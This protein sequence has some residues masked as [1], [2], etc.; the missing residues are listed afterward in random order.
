MTVKCKSEDMAI[1]KQPIPQY[2]PIIKEA[3]R[4]VLIEHDGWALGI[5]ALLV[6]SGSALETILRAKN[7]VENSASPLFSRIF[8]TWEIL[9][10]WLAQL[11]HL[12]ATRL[13]ITLVLY[14]LLVLLLVRIGVLAQIVL[15]AQA[16]PSKSR[17]TRPSL[18]KMLTSARPF[19]WRMLALNVLWKGI[20]VLAILILLAPESSIGV[21]VNLF[22]ILQTIIG[23]GLILGASVATIYTA[24]EVIHRNTSIREGFVS[25][26]HAFKRSPAVSIELPIFLFFLNLGIGLLALLF[27]FILSIPYTF[28]YLLIAQTGSYLGTSLVTLLLFIIAL[29]VLLFVGGLTTA[30]N[31]TALA[32]GF[33]RFRTGRIKSK[34][35]R[36]SKTRHWF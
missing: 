32:I 9:H 35:H 33:E 3:F 23:Y 7:G 5:F 6:G 31:Y 34:I 30:F 20:V 26:W 28:F 10:Q 2:R 25:A 21:F 4:R 27:L 29:S 17:T 11:S 12:S 16:K 15:V 36:V 8:P 13:T 24:T 1:S 22:A 19:F 14:S 18:R